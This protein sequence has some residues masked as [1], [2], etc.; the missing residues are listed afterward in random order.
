[1]KKFTIESSIALVYALPLSAQEEIP[2]HEV[3]SAVALITFPDVS[4]LSYSLGLN[5]EWSK[6]WKTEFGLINKQAQSD[7]SFSTEVGVRR[8]LDSLWTV[9]GNTSISNGSLQPQL[10]QKVGGELVLSPTVRVVISNSIYADQS[11][12]PIHNVEAGCNKSYGQ[13]TVSL[14]LFN[15][16]SSS[17]PISPTALI[18]YTYSSNREDVV[19]A[20]SQWG[21]QKLLDNNIG[22]STDQLYQFGI[23]AWCKL[24]IDNKWKVLGSIA[25]NNYKNNEDIQFSST[26]LKVG[27]HKQLN[28]RK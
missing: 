21:Y 11:M 27:I 6:D 14:K 26:F 28:K 10:F 7:Q 13:S 9:F 18:G 25:Q 2:T 20:Y 8:K 15:Q 1:M 12:K 17:S 22:N 5:S 19:Q 3:N 4:L 24:K 16:I 23:G